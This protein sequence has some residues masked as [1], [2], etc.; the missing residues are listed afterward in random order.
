L[1]QAAVKASSRRHSS[2]FLQFKGP[3]KS[4]ARTD[5]RDEYKK[6]T[7]AFFCCVDGA[8]IMRRGAKIVLTLRVVDPSLL[9]TLLGALRLLLQQLSQSGKKAQ[10]VC[11]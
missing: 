3:H 6:L 4:P 8:V 10:E 2:F 11:S 7:H 5:G 1:T 9:V